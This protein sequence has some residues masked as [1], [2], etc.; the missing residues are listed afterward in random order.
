MMSKQYALGNEPHFHMCSASD[1]VHSTGLK[2]GSVITEDYSYPSTVS[3]YAPKDHN[4]P[5][6]RFDTIFVLAELITVQ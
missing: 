6:A 5:T 1:I 4:A 3:V 2:H